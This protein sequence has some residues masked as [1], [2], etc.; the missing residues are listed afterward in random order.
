MHVSNFETHHLRAN[1][2]LFQCKLEFFPK[3]LHFNYVCV[4]LNQLVWK[5][6]RREPEKKALL[7]SLP[8]NKIQSLPIF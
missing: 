1:T 2:S 8:Q 3:W 4:P 7:L 6:V 5:E